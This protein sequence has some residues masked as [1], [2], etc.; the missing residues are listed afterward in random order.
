MRGPMRRTIRSRLSTTERGGR[1]FETYPLESYWHSHDGQRSLRIVWLRRAD[2]DDSI[3]V[4]SYAEL[5][6]SEVEQEAAEAG[7]ELIESISL[8]GNGNFLDQL[9]LRFKGA[10]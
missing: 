9:A 1:R 7:L 4:T 6:V 8:P 5:T 10:R 2:G 3:A